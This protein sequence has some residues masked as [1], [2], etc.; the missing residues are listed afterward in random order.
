VSFAIDSNRSCTSFLYDAGNENDDIVVGVIVW[1][2]RVLV[3]TIG[4]AA[5]LSIDDDDG[6]SNALLRKDPKNTSLNIL[7][8]A[9]N[10]IIYRYIQL[11][12]SKPY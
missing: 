2:E 12:C 9:E 1:C 6:D 11:V 5:C 3:G 10:V 8:S 7:P 4:S